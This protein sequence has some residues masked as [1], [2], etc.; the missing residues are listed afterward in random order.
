MGIERLLM[1]MNKQGC[2]FPQLKTPDVYI[3]PMGEKAMTEALR[4]CAEIRDEGFVAITDVTGRSLKAQMKYAD[5]IKAKNS[6]VIGDNELETGIAKL[7]VMTTGEQTEVNLRE[8][9]VSAIYDQT[10]A[11]TLNELELS[12]EKLK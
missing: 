1:V 10:L 11:Q 7:K 6:I 12:M 2:L 4:L 8:G 5:K 9:L 3:A